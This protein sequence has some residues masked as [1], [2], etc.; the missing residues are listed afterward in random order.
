MDFMLNLDRP[1]RL[2]FNLKAVR[3]LAER[4][5][6]PDGGPFSLAHIKYEPINLPALLLALVKWDSPDMTEQRVE[7]LI[8]SA[9][10]EGRLTLLD[11]T[12]VIVEAIG[13]QYGVKEKAALPGLPEDVQKKS[14]A[15]RLTIPRS[16]K[17]SKP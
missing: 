11:V 8:D 5:P 4:F 13:Y 12:T 1:R 10:D 2:V 17:R 9:I 16:T 14:S 3:C 7:Q 6:S 15:A